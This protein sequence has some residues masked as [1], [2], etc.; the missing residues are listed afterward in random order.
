MKRTRSVVAIGYLALA[1][2]AIGGTPRP[3]EAQATLQ[4]A[5]IFGTVSDASGAS[6]PGALV[7]VSSPSLQGVQSVTTDSE[8]GYRIANL[9]AG[10]YRIVVS[11]SGFQN[12]IRPDVG[13]TAGFA[14][15]F[16]VQL[17]LGTL[18]ETI[19]VSGSS[20]VIDTSTSV[21]S[22][23]LVRSTL[24][25]VPTTR[26]V[27]QAVY[28][29]PGVRPSSTPDVGGSQLGQQQNIGGYGYN[30]GVTL[31]ID[32]INGTQSTSFNGTDAPGNFV[33]Y[34]SLEEFKVISAG[35]DAD[36]NPAGTVVMSIMKSGGNDY[37]GDGRFAF[38]PQWF[39]K[40]NL[41]DT[42]TGGEKANQLKYF[43][44]VFGDLGGRVLRD[45]LWFYGGAHFQRN[46]ASVFGY[47]GPDG[48]QGFNSTQQ[49]NSEA[50]ITY[51][52]TKDMRVMRATKV[53]PQYMGSPTV[54]FGS[55]YDYQLPFW[56]YKGEMTWASGGAK[57]L[58]DVLGG[59]MYQPYAYTNQPGTDVAGNPWIVNQSTGQNA[60]PV[61]NISSN[62]GGVHSRL[63]FT[64]SIS[65]YPNSKHSYQFGT[66]MYLPQ[67]D[68]K[69]G[70]NHDSGNY[71]LIVT[72]ATAAAIRPLQ[73]V[74]FNYP[75]N[76]E[77][78]QQAVG[79]Y[80]KDVWRLTGRLTLNYGVRWDYNRVY[81]DEQVAPAGPFSLG[82]TFPALTVSK[83][84]RFTPRTGIAYDLTGSGKTVIRASYGMYNIPWLGAFDLSNYN[85]TGFFTNTY[86]WQL[87]SCQVTQ[88]T[89]CAPSQGFLNAITASIANPSATTFNGQN[90]YVSSTGGL[91][92]ILN[93]D[94]KMPYFHQF[95]ATVERELRETLAMRVS[96]V[97]LI[98][99][100]EYDQTF[101]NRP[102]SSYTEAFNTVYP[103]TDP[104]NAGKPITIMYYPASLRSANQTMFVN[105]DGHADYFRT[106]EMT[107][108]KRHRKWGAMGTL[109]LTK[110]HKWLTGGNVFGT[111]ISSAQ[112]AAP[113][114][115]AFPLDQTWDYTFKSYFTYDLP[116]RV[117]FALN[118]QLLAGAPNYAM[119][120]FNLTAQGLGTVTIPV[121]EY[122]SHRAPTLHVLNLRFG[123]TVEFKQSHRLELAV[124]LFNALNSS[125][126]T[127]V[128]FIN[129]TG[130]RA[131][132]YTSVYMA[133]MVGRMGVTYRF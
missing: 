130:T 60:G 61:H 7:E 56:N 71:E 83:V 122:G 68:T 77:G 8:G 92:S 27:Y 119:D 18:E 40:T 124:E 118:Y 105:R 97:S 73:L 11:L 17:K 4:N 31:L 103:A 42:A 69:Y 26:S 93:P 64:G 55:T 3:A 101:P 66:Q 104:V 129:G 76:A 99:Q 32:G 52:A 127:T 102:I 30:G 43:Y 23:D 115:T 9:P 112:P 110:N 117:S 6:L 132:G 41:P 54:A 39:Q 84:S 48:A 2:A 123:K 116:Y 106:V 36:I 16:D 131:F 81:H 22:T 125:A 80:A 58:V 15:R 20:P 107:L 10:T 38:Q 62:D 65:Y 126:G 89:N 35:A 70:I 50:K 85:P 90:I 5:T 128:N 111:G 49:D 63:Q 19:T 74:T 78:K 109:G 88:S 72:G 21:V 114:Q 91:N 108:N 82:G 86:N 44:D 94:L 46:S 133:P 95:T 67:K 37:H 120:Q 13:L 24:D 29:A 14:A 33:D 53:S 121:E 25:A 75:W 96:F 34:D 12:A 51:V 87:D 113:Y 45:K 100:N 59:N 47:V 57:W 28:M 1:L 79:L 98:E